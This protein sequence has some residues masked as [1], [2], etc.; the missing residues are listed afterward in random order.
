MAH[1]QRLGKRAA[2][3]GCLRSSLMHAWLLLLLRSS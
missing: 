2:I 3:D 1:A